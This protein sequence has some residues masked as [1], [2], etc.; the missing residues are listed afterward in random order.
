[1][2]RLHLISGPRNISTAI[3]YSF[4][5]RSDTEVIDEPFYAHYLTVTDAKHPGKEEVLQTMEPDPERVKQQVIFKDYTKPVVFFKDMAHHL[6]QMDLSFLNQLTNIFLIRDPRL[7]IISLA[8]VIENP[9]MR[10]VGIE[11][12]WHLY[13]KLKDGKAVVLDSEELLKNPQKVLTELCRQVEIPFG[14]A[15]LQWKAGPRPEDGV[16]AKYWYK[17]VHATTGFK[18]V[19]TDRNATIPDK[20]VPLLEEC[21]PYY[22]KL[23]SLAIKV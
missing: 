21:M 1:M 10:D 19:V 7:L 5:Q 16:W 9:V 11:N 18:P 13:Q 15:M 23:K 14:E 20:L 22:E 3:M 8:K 17:N 4:A 2:K 12:E 6:I